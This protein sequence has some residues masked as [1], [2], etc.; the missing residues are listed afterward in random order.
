MFYIFIYMDIIFHFIYICS[1]YIYMHGYYI[2][3]HFLKDDIL[4]YRRYIIHLCYRDIGDEIEVKKKN[5][6]QKYYGMTV[7]V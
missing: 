1:T 2:L 3:F 7:G 4:R 5:G 6:K